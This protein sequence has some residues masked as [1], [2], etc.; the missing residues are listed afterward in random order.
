MNKVRRIT[1][2][3]KIAALSM[4]VFVVSCHENIVS[5][6]RHSDS[7]SEVVDR[8]EYFAQKYP[9]YVEYTNISYP[10]DYDGP[11]NWLYFDI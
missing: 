1:T 3:L 6:S 2:I 5:E 10:I 8:R 11:M 4:S 9:I 7:S